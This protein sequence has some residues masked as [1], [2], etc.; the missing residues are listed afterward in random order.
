MKIMPGLIFLNGDLLFNFVFFADFIWP[1]TAINQISTPGVCAR[2][3]ITNWNRCCINLHDSD[4]INKISF[5]HFKL[6]VD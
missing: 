6:A 5:K 1:S 3:S 4:L 2:V